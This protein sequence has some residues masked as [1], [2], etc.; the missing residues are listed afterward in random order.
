MAVGR[1]EQIISLKGENNVDQAVSSAKRG[2]LGLGQ[3]AN[4]VGERAGDL[5]RGFRGVGDILGKVGGVDLGPLTDALGGVEGVIKGFGPALNPLTIGLTAAAGIAYLTYQNLEKART[6]ALTAEIAQ[7][8]AA[9]ESTAE[10]AKQFN[11]SKELLGV[12][13]EVATV[14]SIQNEARTDA[15][16]LADASVKLREAE[17]E[18]DKEKIR[19]ANVEIA[20][21]KDKIV[22]REIDLNIQKIIDR[23]QDAF[24][25]RQE[26]AR[27]DQQAE[28]D[29]I[30]GIMDFRTRIN[31]RA[32]VQTRKLLELKREEERILYRLN[33]G[34]YNREK[35][36]KRL[37]EIVQQRKEIEA[38]QLAD[39]KEV[40]A[41]QKERADKGRQYAAEE[42]SALAAL[43]QARADAAASAGADA[44]RVFELQMQAIREQEAAEIKAARQSEGTAKTRAA[45]I[46]TIQIAARAKEDKLRDEAFAK[47]AEQENASIDAAKRVADARL[48]AEDAY[49]KAQIATATDPAAK[50]A[51]QLADL[52]VQAERK[53]AEARANGLLTATDIAAREQA[54]ALETAAAVKAAEKEKEDAL[55]KTS[56]EAARALQKQIDVASDTVGAAASVVAAYQGKNGLGTALSETVKQVKGVS[57][58]WADNTD[59]A[60]SLIGAVGNVAASFVEGEREKAGVLAIMSTAQAIAAAATGNIPQAVAFGAAAALYGSIAGGIVSTGGA[61]P[62]VGG[63]GF[64]AGPAAAGG[65]GGGAGPATTVINFN[66]PLG[67]S[68]EI[69]KSVVKAQ[70]AA[71]ASGY[72]PAMGMGV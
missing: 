5:E 38:A 4:S 10:L 49:R 64:A 17:I 61:A 70:K 57:A 54:I 51:L 66:A 48:A 44:Q 42:R 13:R 39:A 41:K 11:I 68:Y 26:K 6:A 1:V 22:Q 34:D 50:F 40:Q 31:A 69:G 37:T 29:R 23:E 62:S 9:K 28:E 58:G 35:Q 36:E 56:E 18:K 14:E 47:T 63:G 72:Q 3:A 32:E 25:G 12:G 19:L 15:N 20:R 24:R 7:I 59:K 53:V 21:I 60:G 27:R 45:K 8:N 52:Q 65:T 55:R 43:T 2:L 30:N 67:T 16:K 71:S 46:E 33:Q